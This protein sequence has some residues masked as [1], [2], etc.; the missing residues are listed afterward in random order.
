MPSSS[1]YLLYLGGCW[2]LTP[3]RWCPN[4]PLIMGVAGWYSVCCCVIQLFPM[5][6]CGIG[7]E[8]CSPALL[9]E[10]SSYSCFCYLPGVLI[11]ASF[12]YSAIF[13]LHSCSYQ[14]V[15][16]FVFFFSD[17][18]AFLLESFKGSFYHFLQERDGG[19]KFF[20]RL[21]DNVSICPSHRE[22]I[23]AVRCCLWLALL[24]LQC[25]EDRILL[26]LACRICWSQLKWTVTLW[27]VT[28]FLWLLWESLPLCLTVENLVI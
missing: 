9:R 2:Y 23:F 3:R 12:S 13:D 25:Y 5:L 11:G 18:L 26:I 7:T 1:F 22:G 4:W 20:Q 28:S 14:W 15:F 17:S 8:N 24:F 27:C 10:C 19:G 6:L 21:C 16:Y